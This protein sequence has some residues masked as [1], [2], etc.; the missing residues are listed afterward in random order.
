MMRWSPRTDDLDR[1]LDSAFSLVHISGYEQPKRE[2]FG[3]VGSG[4]FDYHRIDVEDKAVS[5]NVTGNTAVVTG[6]GIFNA[7]I[8]GM[9]APWRLQLTMRFERRGDTW[10]IM[11][12][13]YTTY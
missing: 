8:N 2:W 13:R 12:A 3:V 9:D 5:V 4:Q 1:L 10:T 11:H 6:R 7:T